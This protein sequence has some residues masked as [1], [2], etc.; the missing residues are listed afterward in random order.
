MMNT[1]LRLAKKIMKKIGGVYRN[2]H[3][4]LMYKISV[5]KQMVLFYEKATTS[6]K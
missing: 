2:K 3:W 4:N 6:V 5:F 1:I